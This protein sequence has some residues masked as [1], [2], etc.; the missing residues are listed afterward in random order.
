MNLPSFP[1]HMSN[2]RNAGNLRAH[3][4]LHN[5]AP[6]LCTPWL[7]CQ[8]AYSGFRQSR[9]LWRAVHARRLMSAA[10]SPRTW[11]V[12]SWRTYEQNDLGTRYVA[13]RAIPLNICSMGEQ[14]YEHFSSLTC[15][16]CVAGVTPFSGRWSRPP[17][18]Q[19]GRGGGL[20]PGAAFA[21]V[22]GCHARTPSSWTVGL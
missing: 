21:R 5:F 11:E 9:P 7:R 10:Q 20:Q 15:L 13:C 6:W 3:D 4:N 16:L 19:P 2:D 1:A 14:S 22:P 8:W 17:G 18:L 12:W